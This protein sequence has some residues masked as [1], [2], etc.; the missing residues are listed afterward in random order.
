MIFFGSFLKKNISKYKKIFVICGYDR[1]NS[2]IIYLANTLGI[3]TYEIQHGIIHKRNE[4]VYLKRDIVGNLVS[5]NYI[6]WSEEYSRFIGSREKVNLFF[7]NF[8]HLKL[9]KFSLENIS[10]TKK[11]DL[12]L[13]VAFDDVNPIPQN[14]QSLISKEI[15]TNFYLRPHPKSSNKRIFFIKSLSNKFSNATFVDSSKNISSYLKLC[16]LVLVDISSV[17]IEMASFKKPA[18]YYNKSTMLSGIHKNK[19]FIYY[20]EIEKLDQLVCI[21]NQEILKKIEKINL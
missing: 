5:K 20:I 12:K 8:E 16:D 15:N 6:L 18:Y 1:L 19:Q 2:S 17:C 10:D 3:E 14:I 9:N 4:S 13:L 21:Y 7:T 11:Y